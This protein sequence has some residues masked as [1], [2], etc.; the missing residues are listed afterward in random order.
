M[1]DL[2]FEPNDSLRAGQPIKLRLLPAGISI[3][4]LLEREQTPIY[5][6]R[7]LKLLPDEIIVVWPTVSEI[8]VP[9]FIGQDII[10]E[11]KCQLGTL[12][13]DSLIVA[14]QSEPVR[15]LHVGRD[16]PWSRRQLRLDIR[17]EVA[18]VEAEAFLLPPEERRDGKSKAN[19]KRRFDAAE[20]K[21]LPNRWL[22]AKIRDLSAGGMLLASATPLQPGT[23]ISVSFP[24]PDGRPDITAMARVVWSG[25]D[26]LARTYRHRAGCKFLDLRTGDQDRIVRFIFEKQTQL[27]RWGLL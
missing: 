5:K 13:L 4:D 11:V 10:L 14:A 7:I 6:S 2:T 1:S 27:R 24:L 22:E 3:S 9:I 12:R 8:A 17:M 25:F 20:A 26:E 18:T 15:G 21:S 19:G 23:L 16:G